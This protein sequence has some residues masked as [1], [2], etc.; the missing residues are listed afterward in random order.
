MNKSISALMVAAAMAV[1]VGAQAG[2]ITDSYTNS[3]ET[4]EINQTGVLAMFDSALGTLDSVTLTLSG[5]SESESTLKNTASE[6]QNF[7]FLSELNFFYDLASVGLTAPAPSFVTTLA[8]TNGFVT[9]APDTPL[10]LG[11]TLDQGSI[12]LDISGADLAG[13]LGAAGDTFMVGCNT[14]TDTSFAGGGGNIA[15][16]QTTQASCFADITY[17]FTE[18]TTDVP[19]PASLFLFGAGLLGLAGMRK[20]KAS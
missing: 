18:T 17:N 16:V 3:L 6:A 13:F 7:R 4:T 1:S 20:R 19:E 11:L 10:G 12:T 5:M 15:N 14:I 9:L 8:T 2:V